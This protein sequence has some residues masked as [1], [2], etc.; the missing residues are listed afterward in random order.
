MLR[1]SHYGSTDRFPW[2]HAAV[3]EFLSDFLNVKKTHRIGDNLIKPCLIET[4]SPGEQHATKSDHVPLSNCSVKGP[5]SKIIDG[6]LDQT[7]TKM[8][9]SAH[10]A[11]QFGESTDI[12]TY[13]HIRMLPVYARYIT[14]GSV[15]GQIICSESLPSI[16]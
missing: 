1:S 8:T 6:I 10:F 5:I 15:K 11:F 2:V 12:D 3:L 4:G 14:D 16:E 9:A 7:V 13:E